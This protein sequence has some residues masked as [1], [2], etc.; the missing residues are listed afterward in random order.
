MNSS[1]ITVDDTSRVSLC[2]GCGVAALLLGVTVYFGLVGH[3]ASKE[4]TGF[5]PNRPVPSDAILRSR[6]SADQ[7]RVTRENGTETAFQNKFWN[8]VQPGIYV[9]V[10]TGEPLFCSVDKFDGGTGRPTFSKPISKD[11]IVQKDDN[12]HD[13]HRIELR[14]K[15]SDAHLGHL[16]V[17]PTSPSGQRY[18]VNSAA[19]RFIP[20]ADMEHEGYSAYMSL[21]TPVATK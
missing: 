5:D 13:M 2:V 8:N 19:L 9:D 6:L 16:V 21:V 11:S 1:R 10:I 14:A 15:R 17:D 18:A 12:S 3:A 4:T 20:T 7:Y